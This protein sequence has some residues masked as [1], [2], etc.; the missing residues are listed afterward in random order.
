MSSF[1]RAKS[2]ISSSVPGAATVAIVLL[3]GVVQR[4]RFAVVVE[5]LIDQVARAL[6]THL[7]RTLHG[8]VTALSNWSF[9][10]QVVTISI[11]LRVSALN[12]FWLAR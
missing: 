4:Q 3:A 10:P 1:S 9:W 11:V 7:V 12:C 6:G 2:S 8:I 5:D